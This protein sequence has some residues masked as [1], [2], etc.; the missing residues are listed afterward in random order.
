MMATSITRRA[1]RMLPA[2]AEYRLLLFAV[3][4]LRHMG[5]TGHR[6]KERDR[7]PAQLQGEAPTITEISRLLLLLL[8]LL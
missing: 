3:M 1:K 5:G 7:P 4:S 8:P 2:E 6:E